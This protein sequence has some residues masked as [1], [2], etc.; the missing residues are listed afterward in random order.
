MSQVKISTISDLQRASS[1]LCV[2]LELSSNGTE[3][4]VRVQREQHLA[5]CIKTVKEIL[6]L[7]FV[8][9]NFT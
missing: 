5:S 9:K 7:T 1:A 2:H 8:F 4:N 3:M 6:V